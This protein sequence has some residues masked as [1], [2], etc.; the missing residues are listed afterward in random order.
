M[1]SESIRSVTNPETLYRE[2]IVVDAHNHALDQA[3]W[4]NKQ[5][6]W[7]DSSEFQQDLTRLHAEGITAAILG[8]VVPSPEAVGTRLGKKYPL[9]V[10]LQMVKFLH[11]ELDGEAGNALILA[12]SAADIEEA[13]KTGKTAVILGLEDAG[14]TEGG[15]L[16]VLRMLYKLGLRHVLLAHEGRNNIAASSCMYAGEDLRAYDP[17]LDGPGGLTP[18]GK[19]FV[20]EMNRLGMII[21][22]SHLSDASFWDVLEVSDKP[23]IASHSNTRAFPDMANTQYK[24]L[25]NPTD[26]QI[27]ALA[28]KGGVIGATGALIGGEH[29]TLNDVLVRIDYLVK[30]VGSDHVGFGTDSIKGEIIQLTPKGEITQPSSSHPP[31]VLGTILDLTRGL[32]KLGYSTEEVTNILGENFLRVFKEIMS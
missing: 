3:F 6:R 15:D 23:V 24:R 2:A 30:L 19:R 4:S 1:N 16:F 31:K 18:P 32:L 9:L 5:L 22:V 27:I 28:E 7:A 10:F 29:P 14:P 21:D 13:K 25:R 11:Q 17:A 20:R 8:C 12:T 26:E